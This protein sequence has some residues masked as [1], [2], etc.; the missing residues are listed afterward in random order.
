M[1]LITQSIYILVWGY[2]YDLKYSNMGS[3]GKEKQFPYRGDTMNSWNSVFG[4]DNIV[5]NRYLE[6]DPEIDQL[7]KWVNE[8]EKI[9]HSIGNFIVIPNKNNVNSK[10]ANPNLMQDY[11]DWFIAAYYGYKNVG[12]SQYEI[13]LNSVK[14]CFDANEDYQ[15]MDFMMWIE[16]FF[17]HQYIENGKPKNVYEIDEKIRMKAYCGR[18]QRKINGECTLVEYKELVK[19]YCI[20]SKEIIIARSQNICDCIN[21]EMNI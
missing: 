3:W 19:N 16:K 12:I 6:K 5:F 9:Y 14:V 15:K 13:F 11:F 8:F 20:K 17:L 4:K 21:K 1:Y 2:L 7:R 18:K 10:R